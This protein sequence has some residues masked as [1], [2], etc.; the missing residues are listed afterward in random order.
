M[1]GIVCSSDYIDTFSTMCD[2]LKQFDLHCILTWIQLTTFIPT[3]AAFANYDPIAGINKA[4][5][6]S[7]S[8]GF[9]YELLAFHFIEAS[10]IR[11]NTLECKE[12]HL[13]ANGK[14]IISCTYLI[15]DMRWKC[16]VITFCT[17]N[18]AI[19]HKK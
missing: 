15:Y 18:L 16:L 6:S 4:N 5:I 8:T 2:L 19:C 13:M 7:V 1:E 3:N 11:T 12:L 14:I 10:I 17:R 9:L